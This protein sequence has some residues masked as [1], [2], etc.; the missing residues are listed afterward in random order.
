V[1]VPKKVDDNAREALE[2]FR[3]LTSADDPRA[4]LLRQAEAG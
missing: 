4:E 1:Q 2:S 3:K